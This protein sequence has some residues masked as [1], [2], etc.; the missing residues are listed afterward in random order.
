MT[1]WKGGLCGRQVELLTAEGDINGGF[2]GHVHAESYQRTRL[3]QILHGP[4]S[5]K[6]AGF[7][8]DM[9]MALQ[10]SFVRKFLYRNAPSYGTA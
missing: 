5:R 4:R 7:T 10:M 2:Y 3:S 1:S 8:W 9:F 6:G